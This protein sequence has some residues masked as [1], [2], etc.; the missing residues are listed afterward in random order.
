MF[1]D[2][3]PT[4]DF[5]NHLLSLCMDFIWRFFFTFSSLRSLISRNKAEIVNCNELAASFLSFKSKSLDY[6]Q[7]RY[8]IDYAS[9]TG[10]IVL[11]SIYNLRH[12]FKSQAGTDNFVFF[13]TD[14]SYEMLSIAKKKIFRKY[15][16]M[17]KKVHYVVCDACSSCFK[18]G[19]F[20]A[21]TVAFGVRNFPSRTDFARSSFN[22]LKS[23]GLLAILEFSNFPAFGIMAFLKKY[24]SMVVAP[25]GSI[26][27][28]HSSAYRYL[29]ESIFLFVPEKALCSEFE[30]EGFSLESFRKLFPPVVTSYFFRKR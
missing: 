29:V 20:D 6:N 16:A 3:S 9:G 27:S 21:A 12:F 24:Y 28:G 17:K 23:G 15:P 10:D 2:I 26:I 8:I 18:A 22:S 19:S 14:F 7:P 5:L 11:S 13:C 25:L 30:A 4:Y 1:G